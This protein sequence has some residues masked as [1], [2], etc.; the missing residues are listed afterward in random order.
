MW[1]EDLTGAAVT[2]ACLCFSQLLW[3]CPRADRSAASSARAATR[4]CWREATVA[5]RPDTSAPSACIGR[6][7]RRRVPAPAADCCCLPRQR[8]GGPRG[9]SAV[10]GPPTQP[11]PTCPPAPAPAAAMPPRTCRREGGLRVRCGGTLGAESAGP[12][13]PSH[14]RQLPL[15][16]PLLGG[17]RLCIRLWDQQGRLTRTVRIQDCNRLWVSPRCKTSRSPRESL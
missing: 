6:A 14:V 10:P 7:A 9:P 16:Q 15:M 3:S 2:L 8:R 4:S 13:P 1:P 5:C 11:A 17:Q 12:S